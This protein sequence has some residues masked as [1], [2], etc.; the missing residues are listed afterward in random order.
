MAQ[1]NLIL[2]VLSGVGETRDDGGDAARG[3][4]LARVYHDEELHE[5]VVDF[6]AARLHDVNILPADGFADFHA[7]NK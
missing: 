4:D 3:S 2:L 1:T 5:V 7:K 6:P